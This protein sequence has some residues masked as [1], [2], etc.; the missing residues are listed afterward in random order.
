[1]AFFTVVKK[2]VDF[3]IPKK[4]E[5]PYTSVADFLAD[6]TFVEYCL[7]GENAQEWETYLKTNPEKKPLIEEAKKTLFLLREGFAEKEMETQLEQLKA[8]VAKQK[9]KSKA[10]PFAQKKQTKTRSLPKFW[11]YAAAA[12]IVVFMVFGAYQYAEQAGTKVYISKV[13]ERQNLVLPDGTKVILNSNSI[14]KVPKNFNEQNRE[15]QLSGAAFFDVTHDKQRPFIVNAEN[16]TT[17][18]LGTTFFVR[19]YNNQKEASVMLMTGKVNV[20]K[21]SRN[22]ELHPCESVVLNKESGLLHSGYFDKR[23]V[24][25]WKSGRLVF[26]N[27]PFKKVVNKLELWYGVEISVDGLEQED[28][29]FTGQFDNETLDNILKVIGFTMNCEYKIIDDH[30]TIDF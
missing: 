2:K 17:K 13:G 25:T 1:V 19:D 8:Q 23:L 20:K 9:E 30:V 6:E 28:L 7:H 5:K 22:L 15:V 18:V 21:D 26:N 11:R 29:R 27:S 14:L 12:A 24:E 3:L 4:M 10:F 16:L